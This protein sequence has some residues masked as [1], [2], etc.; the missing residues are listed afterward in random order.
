MRFLWV[1]ILKILAIFGVILLHVSAPFVVPF[2]KSREWWIGNFFDS[3][4]R[5][6]VPLFIMASGALLLGSA[7]KT[8]L[9]E[10]LETRVGKIMIPFLSWSLIY[11]F[12]RIYFKGDDGLAPLD[13]FTM[14][15]T[16][17]IYYH[18]WFVYMLIVL[19]LFAPAISLFINKAPASHIWYVI[20]L[21][22][23][24]TSIL[25][26]IEKPLAIQIY[27]TPDMDDYSALRLSGYFLLG[28]IL[29]DHYARGWPQ[30]MMIFIVFLTALATTIG[31]TYL[32]SENRG[33]FV[34]F[35]YNY[36][37]APVIIMT[38]SLYLFIK[39]VFSSHSKVTALKTAQVPMSSPR[40]FQMISLSVFG[41]Y[42]AHALVIESLSYGYF[43]FTIAH[44]NFFGKDIPLVL[45]LPVFTLSVF[46]ISLLLVSAI[47][48]VPG[49]R[50]LLA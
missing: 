46:L 49:I 18:L 1:D 17:P 34:P 23:F 35:F 4:S 50:G 2:E 39:S 37:S 10:W 5:W 12:Y 16:E 32:M 6:C 15:L 28:Y 27:Y 26:I 30:L 43:G 25:P 9:R 44:T 33:E 7:E 29:K 45:G 47:R 19:Y 3:S 42:L 31:G 13:F 22:A 20:A 41:V 21:W 38:L 36:Y 8:S 11:F 14:V 24:W 40:L 48:V